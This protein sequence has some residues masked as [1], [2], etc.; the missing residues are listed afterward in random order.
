ML[1]SAIRSQIDAIWNAFWS[2]GISNPLEVIE[3]ITY[4]LFL[5]RLDDLQ[6]LEE[7]KASRL[8][9]PQAKRLFPAGKDG[10]GRPYE[11]FRWSRFKH[12]EPKDMFVLVGEHIFPFLRAL[13]G[14]GSTYEQ[15][16]KDARF[17]I[18]KPAL[19]AKVVDMIDQVPMEDRD[20]KGDLYE[21]MLGKIASAG[22]NGQFRTPR[23]IIRLM[24][25]LTAPTPK[26]VICDPACGTAGFLVAAG[27]YLRARHREILHDA[28]LKEHFHQRMFHG[29]DFDNTMLRIGSMNMLLHG[30][31]NPD[32]RY[33]D[34][35][36][37]DHAGDEEAYT[38]IL[39]NPPF[40]GSLDYENCAKDLLQI[41]KTKKT[42]L[43][44]LALFLRLLKPG[45]RAAV[46]VPDGVLFGSS[47]AHKTLREFLVDGQ[48]LEAVISLPGGVFKPYAGVSTAILLFTRTD[49]G[50]TD[51]VWFY[52]MEADGMSLD[53]KRTPL[54]PEEKLGPV[55][56]TPL[57]PE[58]HTKN[59]L[60]DILARWAQ[61]A[62]SERKNPRT[63]QSFC[64]PKA[65]IE[66]QGYDL[67]I[68]RYKEVVHEEVNHRPPREILNTLAK[69]EAEIQQGMKDLEGM[70][71]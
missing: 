51:F 12:F 26:D 55:P 13:G 44:F 58:D 4:L 29:F 31:E 71:K 1:D 16:M 70:L 30:V 9:T 24:V 33:R 7:N 6:T 10:R 56:Q 38:L 18:P 49:S 45:G 19:L 37:Q 11:D 35:L 3:Q 5:K 63:A 47:N 40:A 22:Q 17:T 8:K 36:A 23:H 34:S 2:G 21:Y 54:L 64:V 50:G 28:R 42:E 61:R 67:S 57:A 46:I 53:D 32:I 14:E 52:D 69:L 60:P 41:I 68:N 59:N 20:T 15:H 43:L 66:A 62:Q 39:A 27:E 65:D 48:K 25:E